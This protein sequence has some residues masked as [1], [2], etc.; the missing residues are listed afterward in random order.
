METSPIRAGPLAPPRGVLP[1]RLSVTP[2][3]KLKTDGR[4]IKKTTVTPSMFGDTKLSFRY[5]GSHD[6]IH[7]T[8]DEDSHGRQ[9]QQ[10]IENAAEAGRPPHP[11]EFQSPIVLSHPWEG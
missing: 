2:R 5:E 3:K 7:V 10:E 9:I 4:E 1:R 8:D 6:D 11:R